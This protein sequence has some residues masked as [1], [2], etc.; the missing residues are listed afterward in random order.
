L[1]EISSIPRL[2]CWIL[3]FAVNRPGRPLWPFVNDDWHERETMKKHESKKKTLSLSRETLASLTLPE[4]GRVGGAAWSDDSVCPTSPCQWTPDHLPKASPRGARGRPFSG[5]ASTASRIRRA[6][7]HPGMGNAAA[8]ARQGIRPLAQ[9]RR[10]YGIARRAAPS[11]GSCPRGATMWSLRS[12]EL[13]AFRRDPNGLPAGWRGLWLPDESICIVAQDVR[14]GPAACGIS[15]RSPVPARARSGNWPGTGG[16]GLLDDDQPCVAEGAKGLV[17]A[18][19][20]VITVGVEP[21]RDE[22]ALALT[23]SNGE[24]MYMVR[25]PL[26]APALLK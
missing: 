17:V 18:V 6:T 2:L 19:D 25:L 16:R 22:L 8:L 24:V 26:P 12:H 20:H 10:K 7:Q 1:Q 15:A 13:P 23:M 9:S 11:R 4:L 5:Y 3:F 14:S 21:D